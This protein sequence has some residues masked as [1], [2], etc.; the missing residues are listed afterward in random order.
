MQEPTMAALSTKNNLYLSK[1]M[2]G[3]DRSSQQDDNLNYS[4]ESTRIVS[5]VKIDEIQN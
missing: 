4:Q 2:M 1:E 3:L 5:M